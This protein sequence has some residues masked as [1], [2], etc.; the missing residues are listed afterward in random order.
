M[1]GNELR[2]SNSEYEGEN[3]TKRIVQKFATIW[4][5]LIYL[6]VLTFDQNINSLHSAYI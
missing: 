5:N 6:L 2:R 4:Y 3:T 1:I